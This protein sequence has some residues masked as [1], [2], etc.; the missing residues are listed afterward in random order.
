MIYGENASGKTSLLEAIFVLGRGKSFRI[1]GRN[2][3]IRDGEERAVLERP[4]LGQL[5]ADALWK[6]TLDEMLEET[7]GPMTEEERAWAVSVLH[8]ER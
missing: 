4:R 3:L 2:G 1:S 7:G 6:Q 8:P 5:D